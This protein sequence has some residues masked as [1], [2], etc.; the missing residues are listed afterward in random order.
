MNAR[1]TVYPAVSSYDRYLSDQPMSIRNYRVYH[2]RPD[3]SPRDLETL[4]AKK[5]WSSTIEKLNDPFEF[6]ALRELSGYPDKQ[7]EFKLAG[8]TCFCRSL[9]N[10]LLWSHYAADHVGFV[11][12][13]DRAHACFGGDQGTGKRF[14]LDVRYEDIAPTLDEFSLDEFVMSAVLTK[15]TCWAYEQ[16]VRMIKEQGDQ[17]FDVPAE[18]IKE[19]VFGARMP[20]SRVNEI[21]SALTVVGIKPRFAQMQF[22]KEGYGVKPKWVAS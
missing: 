12:G 9:T 8:I 20:Q 16:E 5:L 15:P 2:Y 21:A 11:I 6:S 10:P 3:R 7:A 17:S 19:V 22:L 13:Y 1:K 14:L 18:S 4:V